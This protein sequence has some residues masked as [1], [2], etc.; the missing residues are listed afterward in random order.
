MKMLLNMTLILVIALVGKTAL[1]Q[2]FKGIIPIKSTC[3]DVKKVFADVDCRKPDYV[4]ETKEEKIRIVFTTR[5]CQKSFFTRWNVPVGT[6]LFIDREFNR[7]VREVTLEELGIKLD[8]SEYNKNT[9]DVESIFFYERKTAGYSVG[10][11]DGFVDSILYT[12]TLK[13]AEDNACKVKY[14]RRKRN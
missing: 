9:T 3:K 10:I 1:A 6:V 2:D 14:A 13:D 4:F 11:V 12:P 7:H 5:K 8:L